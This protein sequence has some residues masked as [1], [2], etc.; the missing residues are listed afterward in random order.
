[1]VKIKVL[2]VVQSLGV[3]GL[4]KVA[5]ILALKCDKER[6][7]FIV[8]C[9][10]PKGAV[11]LEL[12]AAG[13]RVLSLDKESG[14]DLGLSRRIARLI[15]SEKVDIL[16]THNQRPQFY[17]ALAAWLARVPAYIHTRHS[18]NEPDNYK[19][20]VLSRFA[21]RFADKVVCVSDEVYRYE[22]E[23]LR[24]PAC[25]LTVVKNGI[26]T[27][28]F[29]KDPATGAAIKG[30]LGIGAGTKV[31]GTVGRLA[32]VKN[33]A[34][35]IDAFA[36][37][38][39]SVPD[40]RLVI[41]GGGP[42][43]QELKMRAGQSGAGGSIIFLGERKDIPA[44]LGMLDVFVL[45]SLSEGSPVVLLEAMACGLPVVATRVGGIPELIKDEVSGL[46]VPSQDLAAMSAALSRLLTDE[47][48]RGRI[49]E[50]NRK[51]AVEEFDVKRMCR[52]YVGLYETQ[53]QGKRS[54]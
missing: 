13:I 32:K 21:G 6:F 37:L 8:C 46:L 16:H 22:S 49:S 36:Q 20:M 2:E 53:L 47:P 52:E 14:F 3:G 1:M 24:A 28:R 35:L 51:R 40:S 30:L 27:N 42:L 26:D 12:E 15:K 17:G 23:K 45:S 9:L 41:V 33:Q 54:L 29:I 7:E 31:V 25:K 38:Q 11:A 43:E 44:L 48:L 18:K 34:M 39:K 19:N 4:E 50:A 10:G 5:A